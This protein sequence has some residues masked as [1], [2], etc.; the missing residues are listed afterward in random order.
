MKRFGF[1]L[2]EVN[3]AMFIMAVGTL[4]LVSLYTLGYR[5]N[6]QSLED[7]SGAAVAEANMNMLVAALSSTNVTW[8][9]WTGIGTIPS[10]G[11]GK[12]AGTE[13]N[14]GGTDV[15]PL[16]NPTAQASQDFKK[17]LDKCGFSGEFYDGNGL[18]CGLVVVQ[19]GTKC[20]ISMRC[21]QRAG[22]LLYQPL[23]FTEVCYQGLKR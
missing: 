15:Q 16:R 18:A 17:V 23:Y 5:E 13:D 2:M 14:Q 7:V 4:G 22:T 6:R 20:T 19:S 10:G 21:G 8:S 11:W 1:T 12:Y 9:A 3:L